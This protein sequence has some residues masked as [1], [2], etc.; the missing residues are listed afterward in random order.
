MVNPSLKSSVHPLCRS[1]PVNRS[2][3]LSVNSL[4][5]VEVFVVTCRLSR[6]YWNGIELAV[7]QAGQLVRDYGR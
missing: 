4:Y 5:E 3:N 7:V 1:W 2:L 6:T